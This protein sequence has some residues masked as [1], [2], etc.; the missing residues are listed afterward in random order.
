VRRVHIDQSDRAS[1]NRVER[2]LPAEA[3]ELLKRRFQII[4]VRSSGIF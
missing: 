4:N 1:T 2:H 3:E